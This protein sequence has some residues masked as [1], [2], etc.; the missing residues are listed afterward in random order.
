M[1]NRTPNKEPAP[2]QQKRVTDLSGLAGRFVKIR[3]PGRM[4]TSTTSA[5]DPGIEKVRLLDDVVNYAA[6]MFWVEER[7][8]GQ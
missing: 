3:V 5:R 2:G 4:R 6:D 1:N 7:G 8:A